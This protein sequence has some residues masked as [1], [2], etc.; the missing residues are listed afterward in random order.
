MQVTA[1]DR[2]YLEWKLRA[3]ELGGGGGAGLPR[4]PADE[5]GA[6]CPKQVIRC[7]YVGDTRCWP[8][9]VIGCCKVLGRAQLFKCMYTHSLSLL[10]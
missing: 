10:F 2:Y 6:L 5:D 7:V 8:G 3:L 1:G 9:A 4:E